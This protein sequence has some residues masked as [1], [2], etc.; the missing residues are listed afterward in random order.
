MHDIGY[1][2]GPVL[3]PQQRCEY[4]QRG[5]FGGGWGNVLPRYI[6]IYIWLYSDSK[7]GCVKLL[8]QASSVL[9][10]AAGTLSRMMRVAQRLAGLFHS[11]ASSAVRPAVVASW[12]PCTTTALQAPQVVL[13]SQQVPQASSIA[14]PLLSCIPSRSARLCDA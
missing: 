12:T 9:P 4:A 11:V 7:N 6:W 14:V 2:D 3:K 5:V 10:A 8:L 13:T 1:E